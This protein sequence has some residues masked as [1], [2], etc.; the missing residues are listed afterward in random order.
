MEP[1][2]P[3]PTGAMLTDYPRLCNGHYGPTT[4]ALN[5][6]TTPMGAFLYFMRPTLW[7]DIA[8]TSNNYFKEKLDERVQGIYNK[9]VAR[10]KKHPASSASNP[11]RFEQTLQKRQTLPLE[12]CASS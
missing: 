7:A 11:N 1:Y 10:E 9:Q 5:A 12:N 2:E 6:A 4:E 8:T 3:R